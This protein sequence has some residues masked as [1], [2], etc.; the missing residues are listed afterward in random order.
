MPEIIPMKKKKPVI[1]I[2]IGGSLITDKR[3]QS[4]LKAKVLEMIAEEIRGLVKTTSKLLVLGSGGGSFSHPPAKKYSTHLG[5]INKKSCY[6][7]AET[8][9]A[10]AR[11]N[12]IVVSK[13]LKKGLPV[14]SI[15]PSS[16]L[17]TE[18]GKLKKAF[19]E[20]V[21]KLLGLEMIPVLHGDVVL[22]VGKGCANLSSD[23]ALGFIGEY[24]K[25]Q[26][27]M[28]EK[29]IYCGQTNGVYD[30]GGKTIEVIN[31]KNFKRYKKALG[32]SDGIDVTGGM[33]RKVEEALL[34]A[35]KGIPG[36]IINGAKQGS[37]LRAV[38]GEKVLGTRVER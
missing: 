10:D 24:L 31:S 14:V 2:K 1:L 3:K 34:L 33:R 8:Q 38:K 27:F 22:D 16:C 23:R 11:I 9:D 6:G 25:N 17:L 30:E 36:L 4:C 21:K 28:V 20:P 5:A 13:L 7:I 37:L 35:R 12:R 32:G 19:F 26:G 18:N 15:T 29:I